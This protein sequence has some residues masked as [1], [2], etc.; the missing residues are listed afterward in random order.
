ML[1]S[2]WAGRLVIPRKYQERPASDLTEWATKFVM[3]VVPAMERSKVLDV[4]CGTGVSLAMFVGGRARTAR[5]EALLTHSESIERLTSKLEKRAKRK[6]QQQQQ[7]KQ[8]MQERGR[9]TATSADKEKRNIKKCSD[10]D[11]QDASGVDTDGDSDS[12]SSRSSSSS[13]D[14]TSYEDAA[15]AAVAAATEKIRISKDNDN[16]S[17]RSDN[18]VA[19]VA[20]DS[21]GSSSSCSSRTLESSLEAHGVDASAAILEACT[22]SCRRQI[23]KG[24]VVLHEADANKMPFAENTFDV[25][26]TCN[27]L[28]LFTNLVQVFR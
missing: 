12:S 2:G 7:Q 4:G 9:R 6:A 21:H 15:S 26:F 27:T 16:N 3:E 20:D 22:Q 1:P 11:N 14:E 23:V 5:R 24:R 17:K 10:G 19:G 18:D 25:V 8:R 13:G 28:H